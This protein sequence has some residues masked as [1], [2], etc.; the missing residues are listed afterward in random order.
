MA[1]WDCVHSSGVQGRELMKAAPRD[2]EHVISPLCSSGYSL[3]N[4]HTEGLPRP[5][6]TSLLESPRLTRT[7]IVGAHGW[8]KALGP[9]MSTE[10]IHPI[11]WA[12]AL[13]PQGP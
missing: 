8:P 6:Q 2:S 9:Y 7:A 11:S 4:G 1:E 10:K 13:V 12:Q 5:K 3:R